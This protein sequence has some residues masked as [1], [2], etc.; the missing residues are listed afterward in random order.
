MSELGSWENRGN[1]E[2]L[3]LLVSEWGTSANIGWAENKF[4]L[5]P[6]VVFEKVNELSGLVADPG[7]E[8]VS[9][10]SGEMIGGVGR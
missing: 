3:I 7:A 8:M 9:K 1:A 5:I 2:R 6:P 4:G 10:G